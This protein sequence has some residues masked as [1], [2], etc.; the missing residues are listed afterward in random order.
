MLKRY[1]SCISPS[2]D[3]TVVKADTWYNARAMSARV[4][5]CEELDVSVQ[6]S[7]NDKDGHSISEH[8]DQLDSS[9]DMVYRPGSTGG[10]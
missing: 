2:G 6:V 10:G 4:L 8:I 5:G 3:D 9:G 7:A 1:W